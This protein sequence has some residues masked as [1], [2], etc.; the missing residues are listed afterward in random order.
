MHPEAIDT[1][2]LFPNIQVVS[3]RINDIV[4]RKGDNYFV[5]STDAI[6]PKVQ[7]MKIV[8]ILKFQ[9]KNGCGEKVVNIMGTELVISF[10]EESKIT[11]HS[12][13]K[14]ISKK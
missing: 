6:H 1:D 9:R 4:V 10:K 13:F 14:F 12:Q 7:L 5:M 11:N 3:F 2:L 8:Y